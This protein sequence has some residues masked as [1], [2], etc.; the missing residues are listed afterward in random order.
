MARSVASRQCAL[1]SVVRGWKIP[2]IRRLLDGEDYQ[3][4]S[5]SNGK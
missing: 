1:R 2:G 4:A 3:G 5:E